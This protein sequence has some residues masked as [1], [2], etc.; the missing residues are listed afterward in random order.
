MGEETMK[1][2]RETAL[3]SIYAA[4]TLGCPVDLQVKRKK[5]RGRSE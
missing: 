2:T 5:E 4:A 1:V 3:R